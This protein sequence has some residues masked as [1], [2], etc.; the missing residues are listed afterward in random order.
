[1][2]IF[3]DKAGQIQKISGF[4]MIIASPNNETTCFA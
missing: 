4:V 1:M 3:L 2:W